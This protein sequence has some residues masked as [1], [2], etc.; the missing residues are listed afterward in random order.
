MLILGSASKA[1]KNLLEKVGLKPDLVKSPNI[2][3]DEIVGETPLEYVRRIATEKSKSLE[4]SDSDFLITADTVVIVGK[5]ILH[6]T[7]CEQKAIIQL[8][9]LSGRRHKVITALCV[10]TNNM[11]Y[12]NIVKTTLKMKRLTS[13]DINN[14]IK[15]KEWVNKSGSYGLQ[16][17]AI[18]FFPFISGCYSN[19]VGLPIP[20]LLSMLDGLGFSRK[21]T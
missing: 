21:T 18:G 19:V 1:R 4:V 6:K 20:K 17:A 5:K 8:K 13:K 11:I 12:C 9:L 15:T 14:Y 3:E 16:G 10:K 2:L 7:E